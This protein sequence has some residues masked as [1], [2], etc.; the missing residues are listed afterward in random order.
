[1]RTEKGGFGNTKVI[2]VNVVPK[3]SGS[4]PYVGIHSIVK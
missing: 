2:L 3:S 1:M 4:R